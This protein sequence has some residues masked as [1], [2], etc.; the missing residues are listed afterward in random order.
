MLLVRTAWVDGPGGNNFPRKIVELA[1]K[2]AELHVVADETGSPTAAADLA[3]G[4]LELWSAG[5]RGL[6]HVAGSGSCSRS[7]MAEEIVAAGDLPARV[8]PVPRGTFPTRATP[9]A[10]SVLC[11]DK[12]RGLGVELPCWRKSLGDYVRHLVRE[13]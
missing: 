9:P 6:L 3:R 7:Q 4:I 5:A 11:V 12:A 1:R 13:D 10:N 2:R 8:S